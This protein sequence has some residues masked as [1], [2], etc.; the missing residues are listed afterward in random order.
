M[1]A[2]KMQQV[3]LNLFMNGL[4]AMAQS[5]RLYVNTRSGYLGDGFCLNDRV[6]G[7]FR[8]GD[9]IVVVEVKDTGPGI[10][11][12]H[13]S[14]IFDP[15]FTTKPVGVG[16]GLGLSIVKKI[17]DLHEGVVDCQNALEGGVIVTLAFR[18]IHVRSY[19]QETNPNCGR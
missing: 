19:E 9:Q 16:T 14:R 10:P 6:S 5:G 17:I 13:L 15:F 11:P 7:P 12:E 8:H 4:Q 2:Q 18:V 3:L 1:D